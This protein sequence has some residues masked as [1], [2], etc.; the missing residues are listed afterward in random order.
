MN[1][2]ELF[3]EVRTARVV[4]GVTGSA[5]SGAALRR[6]VYEARRAG[7]ELVVVL[8]WEPPGGEAVYR[9]APEPSLLRLWNR[10]AR[11]RL[12]AAVAA[13]LGEL[14]VDLHVET[15]VVRAP[16]AE[17]LNALADRSND[18]LVLGAGPRRS[19]A[20]YLRGTVRR[21]VVSTAKAPVLLVAPLSAPRAMRRELRRIT[22]EDFLRQTD[23]GHGR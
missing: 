11:E 13:A 10:Q 3:P 19:I 21:R 6:A 2:T 8:A 5:S 17:T 9:R 23:A 18:L 12:D 22:P 1:T 20:G 14:P 7:T 16:A 4:V 15:L